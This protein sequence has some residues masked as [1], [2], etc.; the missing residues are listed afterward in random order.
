MSQEKEE[1]S[2]QHLSY[3]TTARSYPYPPF[4][5][6]P[7]RYYRPPHAVIPDWVKILIPLIVPM[8]GFFWWMADRAADIRNDISDITN[9][10]VTIR[11][12]IK[13]RKAAAD[14]RFDEMREFMAEQRRQDDQQ[15]NVINGLIDSL[16]NDNRPLPRSMP[17]F[18]PRQ[19][20]GVGRR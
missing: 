14:V 1:S 10:I 17:E 4:P 5:P 13:D 7:D 9:D 3:P 8:L 6:M 11:E 20:D 15:N 18:K 12:D 2:P 19:H 16:K